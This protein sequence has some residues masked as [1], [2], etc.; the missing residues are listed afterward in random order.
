[1]EE[2]TPTFLLLERLVRD[3]NENTTEESIQLELRIAKQL[4]GSGRELNAKVFRLP[5]LG[6][7]L[8]GCHPLTSEAYERDE[9]LLI[10]CENVHGGYTKML[11]PKSMAL[12]SDSPGGR[13][14]LSTMD[15]N[16]VQVMLCGLRKLSEFLNW[17][18]FHIDTY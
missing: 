14:F 13:I 7:Y 4:A 8:E 1:M 18:V 2:F 15:I 16:G 17:S 10:S 12:Q 5:S 9:D 6:P 3:H 11:I